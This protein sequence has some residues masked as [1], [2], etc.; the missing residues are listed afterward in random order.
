MAGISA[1]VVFG[2]SGAGKTVVGRLLAKNLGWTFFDADDF[3]SAANVEKMRAGIPLTDADRQPWLDRM[4]DLLEEQSAAGEKTVMA[5]SAL[6]TAYRAR[7]RV[8]SGIEFVYL[9]ANVPLIEER[10]R[11]RRGHFMNADLLRSQFADLEEPE[12]S[13]AAL[14]IEAA[15]TPQEIVNEIRT[16]I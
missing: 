1:I 5:C 3:H 4:R 11:Q 15:L 2:V 6:K 14:T 7:L 9:K 16:R 13:E 12:Q 8:R 10:L